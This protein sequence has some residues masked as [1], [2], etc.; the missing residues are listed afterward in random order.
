MVD[1]KQDSVDLTTAA[2]RLGLSVGTVRKR[3][4]RGRLQGFKTADG[5]WRVVLNKPGQTGGQG[6]DKAGQDDTALVTALRD[7]IQFLRSQ[8]QV[9]DQEIE[10]RDEEIRRVHVL[11]QQAQ[12]QR[13]AQPIKALADNSSQDWPMLWWPWWWWRLLGR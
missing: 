4:Q 10:R 1:S 7:E 13:H 11:L 6:Q 9:R 12:Q 5:T 8:L 2:D 3:L